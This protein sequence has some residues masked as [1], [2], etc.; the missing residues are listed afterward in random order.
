MA[1]WPGSGVVEAV[2]SEGEGRR[3]RQ[4][5]RKL[6]LSV[7]Y[8]DTRHRS[9]EPSLLGA[10]VLPLLPL[11]PPASLVKGNRH[12]RRRVGEPLY[13]WPALERVRRR[14][15]GAAAV[16]ARSRTPTHTTR[17]QDTSYLN[18][19]VQRHLRPRT[20][21]G[22]SC[23]FLNVC[24]YVP[25]YVFSFFLSF[26]IVGGSGEKRDDPSLWQNEVVF[27]LSSAAWLADWLNE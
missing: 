9:D 19:F 11:M 5:E 13:P 12:G 17:L 15:T 8:G 25:L 21:C 1:R 18:I 2:T 26:P 7:L 27:C 16:C 14:K 6:L 4:S 10:N 3:H 20:R 23:V 22:S 24:V